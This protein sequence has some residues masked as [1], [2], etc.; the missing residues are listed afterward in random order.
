MV[1][2]LLPPSGLDRISQ[3][4]DI[5]TVGDAHSALTEMPVGV[6]QGSNIGSSTV[7]DLCKWPSACHL[8]RDIILY[9]DDAVTY[10]S[11]KNVSDLESRIDAKWKL[12]NGVQVVLY[13]S[14]YSNNI[15]M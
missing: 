15:Q 6:R 9:A 12:T 14:P 7:F 11:F 3:T 2:P 5:I 8:A 1:L 13:K 4:G 10:Y